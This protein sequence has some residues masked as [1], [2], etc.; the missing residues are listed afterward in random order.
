MDSHPESVRS[1][2]VVLPAYN[3]E[4]A[5]GRTL[6]QVFAKMESWGIRHEVIVV[7]D[8]SAD[9]TAGILAE[10]AS[11]HGVLRVV[12]HERNEGYGAAV[13][14]GFLAA[15]WDWVFLM[16][17]DGQF[18]FGEIDRAVD[19]QR[20]AGADAV[21]GYRARRRD[22]WPRRLG[23]WGWSVVIRAALGVRVRDVDCAFKLLRRAS[24]ERAG[25]PEARGAM[26]SAELLARM[27]RAG[28]SWVEIP[29]THYPRVSGRST[30]GSPRVILRAF[31]ELIR[32][33]GRLARGGGE[34]ER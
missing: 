20:A 15:R 11:G 16:D 5:I 31:G 2:S 33:R 29:V 21:L 19:A 30:G 24:L 12:R 9:G 17:S 13:R 25:Y 3:E 23:G 7:D 6:A 26:V 1:L 10:I 32:T 4:G 34:G 22:P 28:C 14:D 27:R 18:D 8:G